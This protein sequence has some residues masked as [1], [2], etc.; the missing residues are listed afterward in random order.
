MN[1]KPNEIAPLESLEDWDEDVLQRYPNPNIASVKAKEEFRDYE[2]TKRKL[3]RSF[4]DSIT[5]TR[6]MIL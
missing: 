1:L 6:P 2:N 3:L 4:I 5:S